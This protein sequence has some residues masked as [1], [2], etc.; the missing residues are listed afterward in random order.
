MTPACAICLQPLDAGGKFLIA[1][2]EVVHRACAATGRRTRGQI[3]E[4]GYRNALA[5]LQHARTRL[6]NE[7][8]R[9]RRE[10]DSH[11][12]RQKA[13]RDHLEAYHRAEIELLERA[14]A[15]ALQPP[16]AQNSAR[17]TRVEVSTTE[18]GDT[19][20]TTPDT[21]DTRDDT[22]VRFSLLEFQ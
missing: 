7:E 6:H 14:L 11:A 15:S 5:D 8:G 19:P 1:G 21:P 10:A 12:S 17:E 2:T 3:L 9:R 18:R 4:E 13:L 20:P 16:A 22:E